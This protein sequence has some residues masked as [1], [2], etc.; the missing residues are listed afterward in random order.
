MMWWS[1]ICKIG[2]YSPPS[3]FKM[4]ILY[5]HIGIL[6]LCSNLCLILFERHVGPNESLSGACAYFFE[7][8][9]LPYMQCG[10]HSI[11]MHMI[12]LFE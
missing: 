6:L 10:I 1:H 11:V 12:R 7:A 9:L 4:R 3:S 8:Q 5:W 2:S